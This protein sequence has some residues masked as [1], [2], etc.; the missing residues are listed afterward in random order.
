MSEPDEDVFSCI[1][2]HVQ[3]PKTV[4]VLLRAVPKSHP[5]FSVALRRLLEL[6]V[7]LDSYD[8]I[9][10]SKE[11]IDYFVGPNASEEALAIAQAI[12]HLVIAAEAV[13]FRAEEVAVGDDVVAFRDSLS[14]LFERTRNLKSVDYYS[15]PGIL[16][17]PENID[18]L[19]TCEGLQTFCVDAST[20]RA[21]WN[22]MED[23]EDYETWNITPFI[24]SLGP[25]ITSLELR[26]VCMAMLNDILSHRDV[27]AT[28]KNLEH[29]KIDITEGAWDWG[30]GLG[31]P[32]LGASYDF[33]FPSLALPTVRRFELVVSDFTVHLPRA[34]PLNLV[35]CSLL[36][37]LSFDVRRG[38][39][40]DITNIQI[41]MGLAAAD[42]PRLSHL[43]IK[44]T[45]T[46]KTLHE[47]RVQW[48]PQ[49]EFPRSFHGLVDRFLGSLTNLTSL[50][51]NENALGLANGVGWNSQTYC[52]LRES[53][54]SNSAHFH[55]TNKAAWRTALKTALS[56]L[57][58][59]GVGFGPMDDVEV[60]L[61]LG[62]C[63]PEKLR[64]F[65]F[66]WDWHKYG[67][68]DP[69]PPELLVHIAR[70]PKLTDVHILFPRPETQVSDPEIDARILCDVAAIFKSN[71]SICR[72][73][74]GNSVMWER[75]PGGEGP[76]AILVC[77]GGSAPDLS[78]PKFY[79][80]GYLPN[81][82]TSSWNINPAPRPPG[83]T[84][85]I[86]QL[87]D[88]LHRILGS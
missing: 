84:E 25:S 61:V 17:S 21:T 45:T 77:D 87:R 37:D 11:I 48:E 28:Y 67:R 33:I 74:M 9:V 73:G 79:H 27:L 49:E 88:L 52:S 42:F 64:Q 54:D 83:R 60:G 56:K 39:W 3:E 7:Y 16:L 72:V 10:A 46:F 22:T 41:F 55:T 8:A 26:G 14:K 71:G 4:H 53:W 12:R 65:R 19:A 40:T 15:C 69:I 57:E 81:E 86:E 36:T 1:L 20:K 66:A 24:T 78:V 30:G 2:S 85:E 63:D 43:E 32:P 13:R 35:D 68:D 34:G 29:L 59:L 38:L 31:T 5:L 50:W 76:E 18:V 80:A 6:P 75:G 62:C 70:F 47:R 82:D 23:V 51:V 58:S 44:D